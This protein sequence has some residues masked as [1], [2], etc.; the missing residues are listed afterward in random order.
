MVTEKIKASLGSGDGCTPADRD[1]AWDLVP[2][3]DI[4]RKAIR[5][6]RRMMRLA[7]GMND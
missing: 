2:T 6:C 1:Q 5:L 3:A 4:E 7:Q